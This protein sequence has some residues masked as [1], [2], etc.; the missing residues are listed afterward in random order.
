MDNVKYMGLLSALWL[1]MYWCYR[2]MPSGPRL[3]IKIVFPRYGDS[4]VKD[5]TV[6][7]LSYLWH[8]DPYASKK[9][10]LYWDSPFLSAD[11]IIIVV[12][13]F[14]K[15]ILHLQYPTSKMKLHFENKAQLFNG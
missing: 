12:G 15:K 4:H 9:T 10:R 5:K 6:A 8:G 13:Q 11:Q 7:R 14:M 3:N 1:P 2:T